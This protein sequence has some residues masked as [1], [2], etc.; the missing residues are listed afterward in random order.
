MKNSPKRAVCRVKL[1]DLAAAARFHSTY[2][3]A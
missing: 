2:D 3:H 1:L